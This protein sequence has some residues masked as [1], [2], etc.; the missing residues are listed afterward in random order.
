MKAQQ[1][2]PD[3]PTYVKVIVTMIL[4]FLAFAATAVAILAC[5]TDW[6][7]GNTLRAFIVFG[8]ATVIFNGGIAAL[9][10]LLMGL[11]ATRQP[12]PMIIQGLMMAACE[13]MVYYFA[14]QL[15]QLDTVVQVCIVALALYLI[16]ALFAW[17]FFKGDAPALD[18]DEVHPPKEVA[19]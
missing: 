13:I 1:N 4:G 5:L 7:A 11:R 18:H 8:V 3:N 9:S 19:K 12:W 6:Q 17:M 15:Y 10:A 16:A 14:T 2:T